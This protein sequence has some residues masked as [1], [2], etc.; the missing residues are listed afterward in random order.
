MRSQQ[1]VNQTIE[2]YADMI[3]RLCLA[4]LKNPADMEDMFQ[5]V[6]LKY[7][8]YD[9]K[10]ESEEHKKHWLIRVAVNACHDYFRTHFWKSRDPLDV[11]D[12]LPVDAPREDYDVLDAVMRLPEKY[13]DVIYL[14]YY[15]EYTVPEISEIL[16]KK[17]GTVY[18]LLSR[19]RTIL[20]KELG[21]DFYE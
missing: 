13:K 1:D 18:S 16:N 4:H 21:G 7:M 17:E 3:Q 9:G 12:Y 8:T 14:F 15:E 2:E 11:L 20:R 6:F 5:N 10:F 19:A